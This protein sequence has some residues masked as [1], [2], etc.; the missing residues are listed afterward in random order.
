VLSVVPSRQGI[1]VVV[2]NDNML[3]YNRLH[4]ESPFH[5]ERENH[6]FR[7]GVYRIGGLGG[8]FSLERQ[9]APL[10]V[11]SGSDIGW[12]MRSAI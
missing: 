12:Q 1:V 11:S 5:Y 10:Q 2:D 8:S 9:F 3:N 7:T 4:D 6:P